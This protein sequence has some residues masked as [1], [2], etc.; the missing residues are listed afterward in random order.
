MRVQSERW[1]AWDQRQI[2]RAW[3]TFAIEVLDPLL[4]GSLCGHAL[5][6]PGQGGAQKVAS[7]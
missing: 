4:V 7:G 5:F 2:S 3:R 6:R 1:R